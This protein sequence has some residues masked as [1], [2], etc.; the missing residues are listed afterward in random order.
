[1]TIAAIREPDA[2]TRSDVL[3]CIP[4]LRAFAAML[5]GG[6]R[7]ADDLVRDTIEQT[8]TAV[9]RPRAGINLKLQMFSTL[10]RLHYRALR[11]SIEESAQPR[12][13]PSSKED[14]FESDELLRIFGRLRD[15]QREALILTVA[16]GLSCQEAAEVCGCHIAAIESRV[17]EAWREISRALQDD[18]PGRLQ[19]DSPG[20]K[21]KPAALPSAIWCTPALA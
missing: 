1:M 16:S 11:P 17:S 4:D 13:S 12:E 2:L 19:D 3:A 9:N 18:S 10:H 6:R 20:R 8:L 15:E 14:G 5:A 21:R 7:R